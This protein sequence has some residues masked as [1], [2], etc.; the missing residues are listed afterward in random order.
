MHELL[1]FGIVSA[2][3]HDHILSLLSGLTAMQPVPL[4][5]QHH[6]FKPTRAPGPPNPTG[7]PNPAPRPP[8]PAG[9]EPFGSLVTQISNDLY[10]L[11]LVG[12]LSGRRKG[13]GMIREPPPPAEP[14][15][16]D[17]PDDIE[18]NNAPYV[19]L[20][21]NAAK[22]VNHPDFAGFDAKDIPCTLE[23][24][25]LPD[26]TGNR[27]ATSRLMSSIPVTEGQSKAFLEAMGYV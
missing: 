18:D 14:T 9:T 10:F 19:P 13:I 5:E 16:L 7:R 24:R 6:L 22:D 1:L 2:H 11:S 20:V 3:Q 8:G 25:D 23:F 15:E 26:V 21:G 17:E 4:L 12:D 27:P